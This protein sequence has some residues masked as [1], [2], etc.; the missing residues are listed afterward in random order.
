MPPEVA[1]LSSSMLSRKRAW[2][3]VVAVFGLAPLGLALAPVSPWVIHG[4]LW[5]LT[6]GALVYLHRQP[7]F[8]WKTLW[9][10]KRWPLKTRLL[11]LTRFA[12]LTPI[13]AALTLH[14][15]PERFFRFPIERPGFWA[16]VM[17]LYPVLSVLPQEIVYR[18][19]FLRRYEA[20]ARTSTH[21]IVINAFFFGFVHTV[22]H[23]WIA[24]ILAGIGGLLFAYSYVQHRSLKW[25]TIEHAAYGGMAFTLGLGWYFVHTGH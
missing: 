8:S 9:H 20:I 14:V 4:L 11:T 16:L 25:A 22:Y 6:I 2:I 12:V 18:A 24:P 19:F 17:A 15:A 7:D 5:T 1:P 3:E 23:N 10:G 21:R 13:M